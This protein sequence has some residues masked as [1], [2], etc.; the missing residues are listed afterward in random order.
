MTVGGDVRKLVGMEG[1]WWG[2]KE[3][4]GDGRKLLVKEGSCW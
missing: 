3:V 2:W 1:C 4:C